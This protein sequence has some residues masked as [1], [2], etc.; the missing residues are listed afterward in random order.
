MIRGFY[1]AA[2]G[3]VAQQTNLNIIANNM[4][5]VSTTAF[6]SQ[7]ASFADL[8]YENINGTMEPV[9]CG[10]GVRIGGTAT[11]FTQGDLSKTDIK[12]DCALLGPGFF[13]IEDKQTAAISYTRDGSF[14]IG[15]DG[16]STYLVNSAG[17]YVLDEG[18]KKIALT[19]DALSG[20]LVYDPSKIGIFSISNPYAL[21][22]I[23]GNNYIAGADVGKIEK[24]LN[25]EIHSG[26]LE[27]SSVDISREMVKVIEASKA[28]SFNSRIIQTADEIEK[29][30]NQLR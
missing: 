9:S 17:D 24:S 23:G 30:I 1:A 13:A 25:T 29:T 12:M 26:Y 15:L 28:F 2:S 18:N 14:R 4:A 20:E 21:R 7:Q 19:K 3:L 6:K 11:D 10:S 5:N 8:L 22:Q 16:T 27:T